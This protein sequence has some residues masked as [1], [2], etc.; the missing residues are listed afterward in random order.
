M[1]EQLYEEVMDLAAGMLLSSMISNDLYALI[2]EVD[3]TDTAKL[4]RVKAELVKIKEG[5]DE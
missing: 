4:E 1:S 5:G 3:E 2:S